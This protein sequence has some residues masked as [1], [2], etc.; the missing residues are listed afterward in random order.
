MNCQSG[1]LARCVPFIGVG[2]VVSILIT[3]AAKDFWEQKPW[4]QW[5]E[6]DALRILSDSPWARKQAVLA[7]A[8]KPSESSTQRT[9]DLPGV[10]PATGG[11]SAGAV[12][13][14]VGAAGAT[15]GPN[16]PVPLFI[17]WYSSVRVRQALARLGQVQG[18]A[19]EAEARKF[20]EQPMEEYMISVNGPFM[21]ALND[22]SFDDFKQKTFL[23]SKKDKSR[24]VEL[25]S[26]V[27]PKDRKDSI[28]LFSF[29]RQLNDK[30]AFGPEDDEIEF[31]AQG[32]KVNLKMSFKLQKMM[33][34]G[35]LDL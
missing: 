35:K 15:P 7:A 19:P 9:T 11:R 2:L 4:T 16:E 12:L 8:M 3:L 18:N 23:V 17:R 1:R 13:G 30:P 31:V 10:A 26:Y 25:K 5:S 32:R 22:L 24:K 20:V 21:D 27:P 34:E 33:T 29:P 14:Q 28:A 6:Q